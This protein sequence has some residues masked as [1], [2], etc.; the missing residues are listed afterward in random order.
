M[1]TKQAPA[2]KT[3]PRRQMAA[4]P[5]AAKVAP[6]LAVQNAHAHAVIPT[7]VAS[8]ETAGDVLDH[9]APVNISLGLHAGDGDV[10]VE[11]DSEDTVTVVVPK[12]FTLTLDSGKPIPYNV[13][14]QEMP[15]SHA[16]HWWS[17]AQGVTIYRK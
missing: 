17:R 11:V 5:A 1:A 10:S 7:N 2:A 14:T 6:T 16:T 8:G 9:A 3:T 4:T 15:L 12:A 13:G